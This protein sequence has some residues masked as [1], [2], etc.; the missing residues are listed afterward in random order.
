[1]NQQ[2][3]SQESSDQSTDDG[4]QYSSPSPWQIQGR[5]RTDE[6]PKSE[7]PSTYDES[8]PPLSYHAQD[9]G[10]AFSSSSSPK[11][12]ANPKESPRVGASPSPT[13]ADGLKMKYSPYSQYTGGWQ[14]PSWARPQRNN[15]GIGWP[16]VWLSIAIIMLLVLCSIVKFLIV[17]LLVIL[18]VVLGVLLLAFILSAIV[19]VI[20]KIDRIKPPFR[21]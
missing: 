3:G 19:W 17:L 15:F 4:E 9:H 6:G 18:P 11:V 12:G 21:W 14:V 5:G 8:I 16:F 13:E 20:G 10:Q 7:H 1:M 2:Q